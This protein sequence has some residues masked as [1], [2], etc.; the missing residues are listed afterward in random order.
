M[1][2]RK[3]SL[4]G[5]FST[6]ARVADR[7]VDVTVGT[8]TVIIKLI[9]S[10][11]LV[12]L[13]TGLLF[14]LIFAYYVKSCLTPNLGISLEEYRLSE[15]ST[16][17]YK[18]SSGKWQVLETLSGKQNRIWVD[19]DQIPDYMSKAV[20]AI[21]DKRFYDHK[22]VDWFRTGTAF[23]KMFATMQDTYGGST[24]TQQLI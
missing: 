6:S 4:R 8:L 23:F 11:L 16:I 7:T 1:K 21:E 24:I 15:S 22:G 12:L 5:L 3:F 13:I 10:V 17:W 2:N 14:S 9:F 20:I 19:L 18:T